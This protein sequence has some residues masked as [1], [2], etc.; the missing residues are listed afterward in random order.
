MLHGPVEV[1]LAEKYPAQH[2]MRAQVARVNLDRFFELV[3]RL[4]DIALRNQAVAQIVQH[5]AEPGLSLR[6][7]NRP[8]DPPRSCLGDHK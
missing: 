3:D 1:V 2:E 8:F 7:S 4:R 5:L 6:D